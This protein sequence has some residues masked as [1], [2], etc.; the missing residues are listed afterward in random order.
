MYEVVLTRL[1]RSANEW[2]WPDGLIV[3]LVTLALF[4]LLAATAGR[5]PEGHRRLRAAI[6]WGAICV[7]PLGA[8]A[9]VG[10][11]WAVRAP[12]RSCAP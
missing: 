9:L 3:G 5:A 6:V 8:L 4:L 1:S 11:A 10:V 7:I 12:C 2:A